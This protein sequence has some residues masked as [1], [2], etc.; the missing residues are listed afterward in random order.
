MISVVTPIFMVLFIFNAP[1]FSSSSFETKL[2]IWGITT[3]VLISISLFV[4][5]KSLKNLNAD[6]ET[7]TLTEIG[8]L[9]AKDTQY[10]WYVPVIAA[11]IIIPLLFLYFVIYQAKLYES[12]VLIFS[13]IG[14]VTF[15]FY[16]PLSN[17]KI[18]N[19]KLE[20]ILSIGMLFIALAD[21]LR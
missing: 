21:V 7:V 16:K 3:V 12:I 8:K 13:L 11:T 20:I 9:E 19:R 4:M 15:L 18:I 17:K 6:G 1:Q 14:G 2:F 10:K 5:F